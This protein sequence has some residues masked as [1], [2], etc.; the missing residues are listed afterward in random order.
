LFCFFVGISVIHQILVARAANDTVYDRCAS[1]S[2]LGLMYVLVAVSFTAIIS[3]VR[4]VRPLSVMFELAVTLLNVVTATA[5]AAASGLW[6]P[7]A[8]PPNHRTTKPHRNPPT[9]KPRLGPHRW[10]LQLNE[11]DH[12][13]A[14]ANSLSALEYLF[15]DVLGS[16]SVVALALI[17]LVKPP[18]GS[19][20]LLWV[21]A[22]AV[23]A[24]LLQLT[25]RATDPHASPKGQR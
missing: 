3:I 2:V 21:L 20:G 5:I 7:Q 17:V 14:Q 4:S 15:A 12:C 25:V 19:Y 13:S 11:S 22:L 9:P 16:G 18:G 1:S 6:R 10:A 24:I 8:E 23:V